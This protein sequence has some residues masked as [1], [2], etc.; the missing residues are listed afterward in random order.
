[1][2]TVLYELPFH[3]GWLAS[4]L[5]WST[6]YFW[7]LKSIT[8][9]FLHWS[10]RQI[11]ALVLSLADCFNTIQDFI[12]QWRYWNR[13]NLCPTHLV[14]HCS[15]LL[16][17]ANWKEVFKTVIEIRR[18]GKKFVVIFMNIPKSACLLNKSFF[19]SK[20]ILRFSLATL[21]LIHKRCIKIHKYELLPATKS[22]QPGHLLNCSTLIKEPAMLYS[23]GA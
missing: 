3:L 22:K 6:K 7:L 16:K 23:K 20:M 10:K 17:L 8:L 9:L 5:R 4:L 18:F 21:N 15:K 19:S 11:S 13:L 1:M 12:D 14:S 2:G